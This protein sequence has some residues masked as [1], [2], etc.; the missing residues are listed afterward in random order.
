M[1]PPPTL[2]YRFLNPW[3]LK[4]NLLLFIAKRAFKN[5]PNHFNLLSTKVQNHKHIFWLFYTVSDSCTNLVSPTRLKNH[6]K[7]ID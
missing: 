1:K 2:L 4:N 7:I 5:E 3:N 6:Q